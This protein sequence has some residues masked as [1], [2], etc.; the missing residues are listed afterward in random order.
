[1][2]KEEIQTLAQQSKQN[3]LDA[4]S[5]LVTH[6]QKI[7][8]AYI[9]RLSNI[10]E[11]EA[12][13]ILQETFLHAWRY[14][15]EYDASF[16]FST[17]IYRIAHQKTISYHRKEVSRGKEHK[18]LWNDEIC[19]NISSTLDIEKDLKVT[20]LQADVQRAISHL[21][22]KQ[23]D[24]IILKYLEEKS[25]DEISDILQI[26]VGTAGSLVSRG[27]KLL[28]QFLQKTYDNE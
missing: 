13:E 1:M 8:L 5:I 19:Q 11:A 18:V 9:Y 10:S 7:L 22:K 4:F 16:A 27:K 25:Y 28:K 6:F 20:E 17:W 14:I 24:V 23:Q 15:N 2:N 21:P 3:D 12:E 26:S